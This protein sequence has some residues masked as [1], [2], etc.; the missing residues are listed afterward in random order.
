MSDFLKYIKEKAARL[1]AE[2][3][4]ALSATNPQPVENPGV[5]VE[6]PPERPAQ[7]PTDLDLETDNSPDD[8]LTEYSGQAPTLVPGTEPESLS[9][10]GTSTGPVVTLK[11]LP[12]GH[13]PQGSGLGVATRPSPLRERWD[14]MTEAREIIEAALTGFGAGSH[15]PEW[16]AEA[17]H[18]E[19]A[20]WIA[21]AR[22]W[23]ELKAT[24]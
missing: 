7:A 10:F 13:W 8:E 3:A 22:A 16:A 4:Q 18:K 14:A 17:V 9:N 19:H 24:K 23:L 15:V 12:P 20:E 2:Q 5:Q 11:P 1:Q 6:Q 21:R